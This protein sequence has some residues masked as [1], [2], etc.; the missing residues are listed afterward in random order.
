MSRTTFGEGV[1]QSMSM[2]RVFF[3]ASASLLQLTLKAIAKMSERY[4]NRFATN[5][6]QKVYL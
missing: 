1:L 4:S 6:L 3:L 2:S 5:G